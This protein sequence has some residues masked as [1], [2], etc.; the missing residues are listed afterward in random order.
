MTENCHCE[1]RSP[2]A[3]FLTERLLRR[4]ASLKLRRTPRNDGGNLLCA[5]A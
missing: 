1:G 3:I 4:S 2:E 5:S